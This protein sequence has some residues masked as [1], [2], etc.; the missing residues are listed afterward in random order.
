[1]LNKEKREFTGI[2]FRDTTSC[3][4]LPLIDVANGVKAEIIWDDEN[5]EFCLNVDGEEFEHLPFL[6]TTFAL[7]DTR[8]T[9]LNATVSL[10]QKVVSEGGK[11]WQPV[12]FSKEIEQTIFKDMISSLKVEHV[13]ETSSATMNELLDSMFGLDKA[14]D[15]LEELIF[16]GW[17]YRQ[18]RDQQALT[19]PLDDSVM[20]S[21]FG[22]C[23]NLKT[24]KV[25]NM[26]D[27]S[28]TMRIWM[29]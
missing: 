29:A 24:L 14:W 8:I 17:E 20:E 27:L 2:D 3:F 22:V 28:E 23:Y 19:E 4:P 25:T 16:N 1:M 7:E 26:T 21:L 5:E 15:R 10:N 11:E 12:F 6:D 18:N 13:K 9:S